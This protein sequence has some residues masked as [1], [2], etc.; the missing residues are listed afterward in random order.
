MRLGLREGERGAVIWGGR[1]DGCDVACVGGRR[2]GDSFGERLR[3][4]PL[5]TAK[6]QNAGARADGWPP[7]VDEVDA[8]DSLTVFNG[9]EVS[10]G[11][12]RVDGVRGD[13][14]GGRQRERHGGRQF[15][16]VVWWGMMCCYRIWL[17][18]ML[19]TG[20]DG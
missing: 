2:R 12:G 7:G 16:C 9:E 13:L 4:C 11:F 14:G 3:A 8:V 17:V 5:A 10:G 20:I 18:A 6:L 19:K 1:V 15:V